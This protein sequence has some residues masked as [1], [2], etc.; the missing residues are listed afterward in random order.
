MRVVWVLP[1]TGS[2][3][4]YDPWGISLGHFCIAAFYS[5][6]LIDWVHLLTELLCKTVRVWKWPNHRLVWCLARRDLKI[7]PD[8]LIH[9]RL[10][11]FFYISDEYSERFLWFYMFNLLILKVVS[12]NFVIVDL[13]LFFFFFWFFTNPQKCW[14]HVLIFSLSPYSEKLLL[15]HLSFLCNGKYFVE[16]LLLARRGQRLSETGFLDSLRS[17]KSAIKRL[18]DSNSN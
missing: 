10:A 15:Q 7:S 4:L 2:D 17:T 9:S 13:I 12:I 8:S 1:V 16:F 5:C 14:G 18:P 3:F 11:S 6:K